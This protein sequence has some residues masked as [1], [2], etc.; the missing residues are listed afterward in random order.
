MRRRGYQKPDTHGQTLFLSV[1]EAVA[2][3]RLNKPS[4]LRRCPDQE[5]EYTRRTNWSTTIAGRRQP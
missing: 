5:I 1:T 3:A 4:V 2:V